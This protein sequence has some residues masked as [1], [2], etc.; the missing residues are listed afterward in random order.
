MLFQQDNAPPHDG[1]I[2]IK[3]Y[4]TVDRQP[5]T[6]ETAFKILGYNTCCFFVL[7]GLKTQAYSTS[8][9]NVEDLIQISIELF[10]RLL[11]K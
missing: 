9:Q 8:Y 6:S 2:T 1:Q 5:G 10:N 4:R 11:R 7:G 3:H